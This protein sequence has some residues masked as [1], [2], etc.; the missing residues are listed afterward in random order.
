MARNWS[1]N[2]T[3]LLP[4]SQNVS[5]FAVENPF[6]LHQSLELAL[7]MPYLNPLDCKLWATCFE[8]HGL[9]KASEQPGEIPLETVRVATAD[10]PECLKL[11]SRI[12]RP[13]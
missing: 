9:P 8:E 3:Q 1:S 2:K 12:G 7:T 4:R 13:F 6:V 10:W 11:A 5:G